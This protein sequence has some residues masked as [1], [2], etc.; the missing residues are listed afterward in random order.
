MA[1]AYSTSCR[2]GCHLKAWTL[3]V[4][5]F[6]A[7][8]DRFSTEGKAKLVAGLQNTR[9]AVDSTGVCIIGSRVIGTEEM[10]R[11]MST[12]TGWSFTAERI[13]EAGER[14][15][16]L[17]R[18]LAVRE[19]ITRKDDTLPPRL[20]NEVLPSGPSKGVRL[21][22]EDLGRMLDEYYRLRGWDRDGKPTKAKLEELGIIKLFG[23]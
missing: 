18:L 2:G 6:E 16:T 15:Y 19:G 10:A 13:L 22:K 8:Y 21:R 1:L 7:K 4:E 3:G 14:I 9:A 20:L 12:A 23:R 11:I 17:E 5:V